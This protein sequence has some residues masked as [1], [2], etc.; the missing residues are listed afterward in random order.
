VIDRHA[1]RQAGGDGE[2]VGAILPSRLASW[3]VNT[4][5]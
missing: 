5:T 3:A 2:E 1:P 4:G